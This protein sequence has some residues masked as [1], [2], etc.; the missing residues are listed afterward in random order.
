MSPK[1]T[2]AQLDFYAE[3]GYLL[4]RSNELLSSILPSTLA[5]DQLLP[6]W[7]D[8]VRNWPLSESK[9][10]WMPYFEEVPGTGERQIMRTEKFQDYHDGFRGLLQSETLRGVLQE[11]SGEVNCFTHTVLQC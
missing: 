11:L 7:A 8:E 4:L 10:K 6:Q 1:L 5:A 2:Q 9:G 3:N